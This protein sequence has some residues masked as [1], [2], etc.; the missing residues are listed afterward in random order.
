MSGTA[1][2]VSLFLHVLR[3]VIWVYGMFFASM[4]VR[5]VA[6]SVLEPR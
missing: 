2:T 1:V 5:P 4:A 6:A 3:V